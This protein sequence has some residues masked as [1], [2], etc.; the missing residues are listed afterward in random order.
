MADRAISKNMLE[1]GSYYGGYVDGKFVV[2]LYDNG[3]FLVARDKK[4]VP[5]DISSSMRERRRLEYSKSPGFG[6]FT[7]M[8][9]VDK[10]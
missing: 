10:K 3:E 4:W 8:Y 2:A 5:Y 6:S 9:D 7:P 1:E